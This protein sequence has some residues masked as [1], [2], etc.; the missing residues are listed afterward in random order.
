METVNLLSPV[1]LLKEVDQLIKNQGER[2]FFTSDWYKHKQH[3]QIFWNIVYYFNLFHLPTFILTF[4]KDES[5]II[6]NLEDMEKYRQMTLS[7]KPI[8]S[9]GSRSSVHISGSNN[10]SRRPSFTSY[11]SNF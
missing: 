11:L 7:K 5:L 4:L 9:T 6:E 2:Y 1:V 3:K 10:G 8:T